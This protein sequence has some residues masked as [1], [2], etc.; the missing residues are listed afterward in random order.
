MI[1]PLRPVVREGLDKE[2]RGDVERSE[3]VAEEEVLVPELA[4]QDRSGDL[5]E[6]LLVQ[7][8]QP[9]VVP[10]PKL[11]GGLASCHSRS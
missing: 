8:L 10:G 6:G 3:A 2:T 7:R 5:Q 9:L 4:G 1:Q 11:K